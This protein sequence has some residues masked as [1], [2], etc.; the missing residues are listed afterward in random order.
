MPEYQPMS[1]FTF[2]MNGTLFAGALI[3]TFHSSKVASSSWI[4]GTFIAQAVIML[5][6]PVAANFE[7]AT[8]YWSCFVL[9]A[10]YGLISGINQTALSDANAKLP[11]N[12]IAIFL[13][14]QPIAGVVSNLLMLLSLI[15]YNSESESVDGGVQPS[16]TAIEMAYK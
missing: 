9:F 6:I 2:A 5:F 8:A 10:F 15:L 4:C 7:G 13:T 1:T 3:Y 14:S 11:T 16:S 12:Y